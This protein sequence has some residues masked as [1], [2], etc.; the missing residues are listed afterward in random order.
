MWHREPILGEENLKLINNNDIAKT[1]VLE[2]N[3]WR[4][5]RIK[6]ECKNGHKYKEYVKQKCRETIKEKIL[7]LI[8][9][10]NFWENWKNEYPTDIETRLELKDLKV[11]Q[12]PCFTNNC[13]KTVSVNSE[14]GLCIICRGKQYRNNRKEKQKY[15]IIC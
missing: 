14:T 3:G 12:K 5:I 10:K 2:K 4:L 15:N 9:D 11:S 13:A 7:L 1:K 8:N 6:D